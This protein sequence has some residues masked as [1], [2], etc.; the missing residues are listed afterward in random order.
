MKMDIEK[1]K[2]LNDLISLSLRRKHIIVLN[3]ED[4]TIPE[5]DLGK[6]IVYDK[7][8]WRITDELNQFVENL[9]KD[10]TLNVEDKILSIF[11]KIC[12]DYIYDDNLISYLRK[13]DDD[14]FT[15]PDWYGRDVDKEWEENRKGH[16]RRVCY[17]LSRYL[18][19]SLKELLKDNPK[20]NVCI[21]WNKDLTHYFVG[22]TCD[23]YSV[24]LDLD[25]FF[26]IKDLTRLK[27]GLTAEGVTILEDKNNRFG[28]A[29]K[30]F[31][32]GR[33]THAIKKIEDEISADSENLKEENQSEIDQN[34]DISFIKKVI[35]ILSQKYKIDSQGLY[36]YI[37]EVID[38]KLGSE[39]REKV[40]K[41]IEGKSRESTR[42]IRCLVLNIDNKKFL[43]DV[44]KKILRPFSNEEMKKKR[45]EFIPYHDLN[46]G[47][48]DYYDGT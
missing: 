8:E 40:W 39:K 41:K 34:E 7:A 22:L 37:K 3:P 27:M 23:D 47:G 36:E 2:K 20:F 46:R 32:E 31:N 44:D 25:D 43:I 29:L 14:S 9:S 18:A 17:E 35:N 5:N 4:K 24:T 21:Y 30:T 13:V 12:T 48:F 19:K 16:N 11:E 15:L 42:Y 45:T 10:N 33:S 1:L 38:I 26:N 6:N 28:S